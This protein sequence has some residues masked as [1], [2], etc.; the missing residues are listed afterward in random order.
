MRSN[1]SRPN[2]E[3]EFCRPTV[4][5]VKRNLF[6]R[7]DGDCVRNML[8]NEIEKHI[9]DSTDKWGFDFKNDIPAKHNIS[10][11]EWKSERSD[12]LPILYRVSKNVTVSKTELNRTPSKKRRVTFIKDQMKYERQPK[13]EEFVSIRRK[14]LHFDTTRKI[15]KGDISNQVET[16]SMVKRRQTIS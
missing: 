10:N 11:Y 4:S 9:M 6:G 12:K 7:A 8:Q 5:S 14:S 15:L 3:N 2:K 13:M 1:M 16:R